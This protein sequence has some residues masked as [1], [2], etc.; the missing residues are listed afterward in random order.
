MLHIGAVP[1]QIG[2]GSLQGRSQSLLAIVGPGGLCLPHVV[3]VTSVA[4]QC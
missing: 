2:L 4:G 1:H 3:A